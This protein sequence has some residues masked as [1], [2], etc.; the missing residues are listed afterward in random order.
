MVTDPLRDYWEHRLRYAI[1][2]PISDWKL[3][4]L[5]VFAY[6][7][8]REHL[9]FNPRQSLNVDSILRLNETESTYL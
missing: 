2:M 4:S 5:F 3:H 1:G 6:T 8:E 7:N 9:M